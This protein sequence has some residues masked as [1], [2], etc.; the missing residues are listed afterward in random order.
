VLPR[1]FHNWLRILLCTD[2]F[3]NDD[4][5]RKT[6]RLTAELEVSHEGFL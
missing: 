3:Y 1:R 4:I 6:D 5:S 2:R